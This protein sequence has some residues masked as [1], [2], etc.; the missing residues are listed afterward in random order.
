MS[1]REV[2][3]VGTLCPVPVHLLARAVRRSPPG[4]RLAL[5]AD[6][7]LAA[8]DVPA[9]CHRHGVAVEDASTGADG[10]LRVR[11]RVPGDGAPGDQRGG[12]GAVAR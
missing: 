12:A 2:D 3:A 11:V 4:A 8:V 9:W 5:L 7:P 10:V 6:D 1:V